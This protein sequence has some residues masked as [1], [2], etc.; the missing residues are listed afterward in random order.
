MAA[1]D[2]FRMRAFDNYFLTTAIDRV[3]RDAMYRSE[4]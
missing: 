4:K 1:G 3:F 2:P